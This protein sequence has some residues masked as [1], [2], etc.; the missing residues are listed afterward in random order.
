[1]GDQATISSAARFDFSNPFFA[2]T[3]IA[4]DGTRFPLWTKQKAK[5]LQDAHLQGTTA[6][7]FLQELVIEN[8]LSGVPK[9]TATLAPPYRDAINFLDS[10]LMEWGNSRLEVI[11]G[12]ISNSTER[13]IVSRPY[14]GI[15]LKPDVQLGMDVTITLNAQGVS[16]F[17]AIRQAGT[18]TFTNTTRKVI[19]EQIGEAR[20]ANPQ[21]T[22]QAD[23]GPNKGG[24]VVKTP[25]NIDELDGKFPNLVLRTNDR[26]GTAPFKFEF[27]GADKSIVALTEGPPTREITIDDSAVLQATDSESYKLYA[28][29][30]IAFTQG[31]RTDWQAIGDLCKQCQIYM[32][33]IGSDLKLIPQNSILEGEPKRF[34]RLFDYPNGAIGPA[35]GVFPILSASSPNMA[36]YLP[37]ASRGLFMCDVNSE[38]RECTP[39][40]I[41]DT[42]TKVSRTTEGAAAPTANKNFPATDVS[43]GDG[44]ATHPGDPS[45]AGVVGAARAEFIAH[46]T[47]MGVALNLDSL[48]DPTLIPGDKIAVRGLGARLKGTYVVF[49]QTVT[50]GGSGAAMTL[51]TR[52]NAS[53]IG[54][55]AAKGNATKDTDPKPEED[56]LNI[57][58]VEIS[59]TSLIRTA[60]TA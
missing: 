14:T 60:N 12:Y 9:I 1:M 21:S 48:A 46:T 4:A 3:I 26:L 22:E 5:D 36:V 41:D 42:S 53:K 28:E 39:E 47:N 50:I 25:V 27:V 58:A 44:A 23:Y 13:V 32:L 33:W 40:V 45:D 37:G 20:V 16:S 2:A 29:S 51:E 11:Y 59:E 49:K 43:T 17:S 24:G 54:G 56:K 19:I 15:L 8:N 34:F 57:Q 35:A 7:S 18:R 30:P 38:S 31:G 52:S 10:K 6:L 55:Q